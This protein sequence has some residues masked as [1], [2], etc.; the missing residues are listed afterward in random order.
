[1]I[2]IQTVVEL[3]EIDEKLIRGD[4]SAAEHAIL[5]G[6]RSEIMQELA[7]QNGTL[8]Q[9]L[10]ASK[11]TFR[12]GGDKIGLH[13]DSVRD[14]AER[15]GEPKNKVQRSKERWEILGSRPRATISSGLTSSLL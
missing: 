1:M 2:D 8:S 14:Q 6:Q 4:L 7:A 3:V 10:T 11:Q 13:V 12:R 9:F 15:T 5:T